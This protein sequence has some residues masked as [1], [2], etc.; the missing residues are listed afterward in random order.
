MELASRAFLGI[1]FYSES[2][3]QS[4][5]SGW[6]AQYEMWAD[7]VLDMQEGHSNPSDAKPSMS[8]YGLMSGT[9]QGWDLQDKQDSSR[10]Q[11]LQNNNTQSHGPMQAQEMPQLQDFR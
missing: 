2:G 8:S 5:I 11:E 7:T 6:Q 4:V 10:N 9:A 3:H 1:R